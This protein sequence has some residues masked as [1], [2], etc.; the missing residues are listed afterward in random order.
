[1]E[2]G[3]ELTLFMEGARDRKSF[4]YREG[5]RKGGGDR[6]R[7]REREGGGGREGSYLFKRTFPYLRRSHHNGLS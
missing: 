5:W 6:K 1:M 2:G 7:G 4:L 3:R